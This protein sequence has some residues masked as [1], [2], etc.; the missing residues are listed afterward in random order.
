MALQH[1]CCLQAAHGTPHR[2]VLDVDFSPDRCPSQGQY[3]LGRIERHLPSFRE[4]L[5][6]R[7]KALSGANWIILEGETSP[8]L[9][10]VCPQLDRYLGGQ[11]GAW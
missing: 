7:P 4:V 11:N 8:G 10:G 3:Q 9:L 5:P 2:D 1:T 6:R